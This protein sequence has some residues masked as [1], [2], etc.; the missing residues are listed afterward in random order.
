MQGL[1]KHTLFHCIPLWVR[2]KH[3]LNVHSYLDLAVFRLCS[4]AKEKVKTQLVTLRAHWKPYPTLLP[5]PVCS[6]KSRGALT[7]C[8]IVYSNAYE[9]RTV[10]GITTPCFHD[11]VLL[12]EGWGWGAALF[13]GAF[14]FAP[15]V[16]W[17]WF[18]L[19][20]S[21]LPVPWGIPGGLLHFPLPFLLLMPIF[22][23]TAFSTTA[24]G[25]HTLS[26]PTKPFK[27]AMTLSTKLPEAD[28]LCEVTWVK[29]SVINTV[30]NHYTIHGITDVKETSNLQIT[31]GLGDRLCWVPT[32]SW[33]HQAARGPW[34]LWWHWQMLS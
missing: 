4:P 21:P 9:S 30:S 12:R 11:R 28:D 15:L 14:P 27:A 25:F 18:F 2:E 19:R 13:P 10:E 23:Q 33:G 34:C 16:E 17:G 8:E 20:A 29:G 7:F 22:L 24:M 3:R 31:K 6:Q 5:E 1:P 26:F 32:A